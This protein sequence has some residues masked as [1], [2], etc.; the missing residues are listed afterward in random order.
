MLVAHNHD[1]II[2]KSHKR[3]IDYG[4]EKERIF[5]ITILKGKEFNLI[6]EKNND[7]IKIARPFME[8]LYDFLKDL[9]SHYILQ[10]KMVL[11]SL[12]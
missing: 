10:I 8:I 1:E 7:L 9:D 12:L 6:L 3:C 11:F 2:K 5:P 4:V